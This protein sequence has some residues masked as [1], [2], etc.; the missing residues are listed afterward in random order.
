MKKENVMYVRDVMT[1]GIE[2]I[3]LTATVRRRRR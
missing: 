3:E 1:R 2:E